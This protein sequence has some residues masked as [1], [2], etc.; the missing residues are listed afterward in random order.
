MQTRQGPRTGHAFLLYRYDGVVSAA[1]TAGAGIVLLA[2]LATS[3]PDA[4]DKLTP[5]GR[6]PTEE[7]FQ[8]LNVKS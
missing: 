4:I 6:V 8:R 7:E 1:M 2:G 3:L 5:D